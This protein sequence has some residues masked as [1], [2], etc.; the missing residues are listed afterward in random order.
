MCQLWFKQLENEGLGTLIGNFLIFEGFQSLNTYSQENNCFICRL[1]LGKPLGEGAFGLVMK[2][3]A[4]G[5][6]KVPITTV[7]VKMLKGRNNVLPSIIS[8]VFYINQN[9]IGW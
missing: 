7:A 8:L 4:T 9:F 2:G 5:L 6:N 1:V 3:E